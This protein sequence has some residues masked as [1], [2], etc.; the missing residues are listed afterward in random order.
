MR[1]FWPLTLA[2]LAAMAAA[3]VA[4]MRQESQIYDEATHLASGYSYLTTGDYRLNPEHPP[5]SKMLAAVP[6]L[7]LKP[8]LP[9]EDA[10]WKN[11]DGLYFGAVF[12]YLNRV[13]AERMLFP[14]RYVTIACTFALG[15]LLAV[16][17]RRHFSTAAALLAVFLYA[18]DPNIAAHGHYVTNDLLT[19]AFFFLASIM[20]G[21]YLNTRRAADLIG[22]GLAAGLAAS[23]KFTGLV[24]FPV[25]LALYLIKWRLEPRP[26]QLSAR[27]LA[28][29][30][31]AAGASAALVIALCYAPETLRRWRGS[32]P[33]APLTAYM[34]RD[35]PAQKALYRTAELLHLPAHSYLIGLRLVGYHASEGHQAY[36]LGRTSKQ[37][38]W[39]YFPV[40][41][42]VKTPA[43][44]LLLLLAAAAVVAQRLRRGDPAPFAW[45]TL[46]VPMAA[47]FLFSMAAHINIGLRH[48]LPVY[49]FL[50]TLVAAIVTS[51]P[52]RTALT[53]L[54]AAALVLEAAENV[55]IFPHYLAFFN[56]P[57]GGPA[58]GTRYLLD[59][60]IDWGQD[61]KNLRRWIDAHGN[62]PVCPEY[63]GMAY[64]KYYGVPE[65][66]LPATWETEKRA[67]L[68]CIGAISVTLLHDVYLKPGQYQWLRQLHPIGNVGYSINLYDLRK[69]RAP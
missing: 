68:D 11:G 37:G 15:L 58:N 34:G 56:F 26:R 33:G 44:V 29:S 17:A 7:F 2:L 14:A 35:T 42:A 16:W 30:M 40:A 60:N 20:W 48:I 61:M 1:A 54:V 19:A 4:A 46:A 6:L 59:S 65:N 31:L 36:L 27:R 45:Y 69:G 32:Q 62:P 66:S 67:R 43:A 64:F 3:Q 39:Y 47:Y 55:M 57:S 12:L 53:T 9:V 49:P 28:L 63:F 23:T 24:L 38:W 50:F 51:T 8:H 41:F 18:F 21:R 25:F 5:L 10:S 13:D 22:A 52:R